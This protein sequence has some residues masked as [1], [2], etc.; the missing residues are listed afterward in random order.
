MV[1]TDT[2]RGRTLLHAHDRRV[3]QLQ[4]AEAMSTNDAAISTD[5]MMAATIFPIRFSLRCTGGHERLQR[6]DLLC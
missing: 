4:P 6:N 2:A 5:A 1:Q 3:Y